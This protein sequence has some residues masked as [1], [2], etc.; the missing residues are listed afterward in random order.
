[1]RSNLQ[2]RRPPPP[3]RAKP[4]IPPA[5]DRPTPQV[6][7]DTPALRA[8]LLAGAQTLGLTLDDSHA[9]RLLQY[10]ALLAR[11][12]QVYNLTA[13]R[14]PQEMLRH[15]L[16][17]SLAAVPAMRRH[18]ATL[19][20]DAPRRLLDVGSGGGLPGVVL[21]LLCPALSVTC[22]DTVGKKATF[23]RQAG[24]ELGLRNLQAQHAR[25]ENLPATPGYDVITAR[26]FASLA[27]LCRLTHPLLT[28]GGVWMAMKGQGPDAERAELP[29]TIDVFHVEHLQVPGLD[30]ARCLVWM[31]PETAAAPL[32]SALP[33]AN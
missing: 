10:L 3:A 28:P 9:D 8:E 31:R 23:I 17:D 20:P 25:V 27:D 22:V 24:A 4:D 33:P 1:M 2:R 6:R 5:P 32:A 13:V 7:M 16:L 12:T 29:A 14:D 19:P 11:W 26:A 21:A 30:A 18:L 15:H